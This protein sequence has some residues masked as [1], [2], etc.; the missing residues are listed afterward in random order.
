MPQILVNLSGLWLDVKEIRPFPGTA[1]MSDDVAHLNNELGELLKETVGDISRFHRCDPA[2]AT[3][4]GIIWHPNQWLFGIDGKDNFLAAVSG[5]NEDI[6]RR[7]DRAMHEYRSC[8]TDEAALALASAASDQADLVGP[9][10][11]HLVVTDVATVSCKLT[12]E[13]LAK[14]KSDPSQWALLTV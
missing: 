1:V 3:F 9:N 4:Y 14:I 2:L 5:W 10:S 8:P 6:K 13:D 11:G 12:A 7:L